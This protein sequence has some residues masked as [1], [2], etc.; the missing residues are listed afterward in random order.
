MEYV[1]P[2]LVM[3]GLCYV[4][5]LL[6]ILTLGGLFELSIPS[7]KGL[8]WRTGVLAGCTVIG[9]IASGFVP[10]PLAGM[11]IPAIFGAAALMVLF[12]MSLPEDWTLIAGFTV[13]YFIAIVLIGILAAILFAESGG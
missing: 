1:V 2:L 7:V 10:L 5:A 8:I 6:V 13:V 4:A 3:F 12:E 11:V 9:T